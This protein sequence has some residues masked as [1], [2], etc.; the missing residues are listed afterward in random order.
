VQLFE[1]LKNTTSK[2]FHNQTTAKYGSLKKD[3][4]QRNADPGYFTNL[5]ELAI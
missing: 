1:F 2:L 3:Q 4:N 5:K